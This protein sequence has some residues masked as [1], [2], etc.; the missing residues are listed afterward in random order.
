MEEGFVVGPVSSVDTAP[1]SPRFVEMYPGA[2]GA[3]DSDESAFQRI[4]ACAD[5]R[6]VSIQEYGIVFGRIKMVEDFGTD[7]STE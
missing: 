2:E 3:I 6:S 4:R 5:E 7:S 1:E